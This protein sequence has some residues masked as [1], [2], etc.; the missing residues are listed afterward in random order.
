ML[1]AQPVHLLDAAWREDM[2]P[3]A[4][5]MAVH[6]LQNKFDETTLDQFSDRSGHVFTLNS[7]ALGHPRLCLLHRIQTPSS[8]VNVTEMKHDTLQHRE[9]LRVV[10]HEANS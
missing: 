6:A 4:L 10:S 2:D 8:R 1:G 3:Q 5:P 7:N 9:R